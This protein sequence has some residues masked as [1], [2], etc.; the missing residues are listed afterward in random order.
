ML[1]TV[2]VDGGGSG[3]RLAAFNANGTI[4]ATAMDGPASLALGEEQS[5]LHIRRGLTALASQL[6]KSPDWLPGRLNLGLAGSL[7]ESRRARFLAMLPASINCTLVSDGHAQLL[8]A[9][10]GNSGA[11][12][13]VGTGSVLHWVDE[14]GHISMVGGWGYPVGDEGSGA[15]LGTRL[16]NGYLWQRDSGVSGKQLAPVFQLLENRIGKSTSDVQDWTTCT[17]STEL[18]SLAPLI[19]TAADQGDSIAIGLLDD[20]AAQCEKLLSLA[21]Q[22]L[23]IY[24]VGGLAKTYRSRFTKAVTKRLEIPHGTALDGLFS[25]TDAAN[26]S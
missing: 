3:C 22:S 17:R 24:L 2:A 10:A 14:T 5:W 9:T 4:C 1:Y 6:G 23:A 13:A 7:S 25:L 11:C 8:G 16:I 19:V 20:G 21:P 18:A 26:R 15:W 12:L